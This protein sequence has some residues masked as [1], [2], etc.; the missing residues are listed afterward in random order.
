MADLCKNVMKNFVI[1]AFADQLS[2][3]V[4]Q[5]DG[6]TSRGGTIHSSC[7]TS[8]TYMQFARIDRSAAMSIVAC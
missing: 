6:R 4:V 7:F 8:L 1:I 3:L 5:T 2:L